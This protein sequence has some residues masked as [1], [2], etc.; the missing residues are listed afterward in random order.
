MSEIELLGI[1]IGSIINGI[2]IY[3]I[4]S[5]TWINKEETMKKVKTS[6]RLSDIEKMLM[7]S[8]RNLCG[9]YEHIDWLMENLGMTPSVARETYMQMCQLHTPHFNIII[10]DC[11]ISE[12]KKTMV[13]RIKNL[14]D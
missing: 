10:E 12:S 6:M 2:M 5:P 1:L 4:F 3:Y 8:D 11:Y 9:V 14:F 7:K 13:D